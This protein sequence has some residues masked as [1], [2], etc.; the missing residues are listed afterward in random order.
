MNPEKIQNRD[1]DSL[2]DLQ[3][4]GW[5]DIRPFFYYYSGSSFCNP[6]KMTDNGRIIA[7]GTSI[8]HQDSSWLAHII[9]HPDY[10]NQG[11]GLKLASALVDDLD[12]NKI[13]TVFLDAT[14]MGYPV[15]KKIGF[16]LETEYIHMDGNFVDVD[17]IDSAAVIPYH[18]KYCDQVLELD[19]KI[20]AE[21]RVDVLSPHLPLSML[22]VS[23][24]K[25]LGAYFP[26]L[27]DSFVLASDPV[28][29]TELMKLRMRSKYTTR[30]PIG[31][32]A[33]IDFLA[34][35]NYQKM[36]TSKRMILGE[37]REWKEE[38]IF[39]RISGGLG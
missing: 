24:D 35:H 5:T 26:F 37:K 4:E 39:N 20:S 9:V 3:P 15:Y 11:L 12:R 33:C 34:K 21:D 30:F 22:Y 38:G 23:D 28:A 13:K 14:D 27:L 36:R 16:E 1:I 29:G 8:S 6:L 25:V 18:T 31:N 32:Q 2:K 10:R 17:L 7:A 19:R